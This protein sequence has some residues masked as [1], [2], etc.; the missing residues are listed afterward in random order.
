ME[1]THQNN[2]IH[3]GDTNESTKSKH[4]DSISEICLV[5]IF[6]FS[7]ITFE[8]GSE[9]YFQLLYLRSNIQNNP[10]YIRI[11]LSFLTVQCISYQ[12][13]IE[14]ISNY[15]MKQDKTKL[16]VAW[17]I[18]LFVIFKSIINIASGSSFF[19]RV[20]DFI[21]T[22][23]MFKLYL[24]PIQEQTPQQYFLIFGDMYSCFSIL[25]F[26][27]SVMRLFSE[28][29]YQIC[30]ENFSHSFW[31]ITIVYLVI[32]SYVT[33]V[34]TDIGDM[35]NNFFCRQDLYFIF[36]HSRYVFI[37]TFSAYLLINYKSSMINNRTILFNDCFL[38]LM[39]FRIVVLFVSASCSYY[40]TL[41]DNCNMLK[42]L[43]MGLFDT[44]P[45][46]KNN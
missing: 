9:Q 25:C 1:T 4:N 22:C 30:F 35:M 29:H 18:I 31:I 34:K 40:T 19:F 39:L 43:F 20:F 28:Y 32:F 10:S 16:Y 11:W 37:V 3:R 13:N 45:K 24:F 33:F 12:I 41:K 26:W 14:F 6:I 44:I 42:G 21:C 27:F 5:L 38:V 8:L 36:K 7:F 15:D 2:N 46:K 23:Y 17:N